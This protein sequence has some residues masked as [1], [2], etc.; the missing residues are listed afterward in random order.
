[1]PLPSSP[2]TFIVWGASIA[3]L[4]CSIRIYSDLFD[5]FPVTTEKYLHLNP[6]NDTFYPDNQK[7]VQCSRTAS[8]F[9]LPM[10]KYV[11]FCHERGKCAQPLRHK[12]VQLV[13]TARARSFC[14]ACVWHF[15][16]PCL[17]V[18]MLFFFFCMFV[19]P[20]A[21]TVSRENN[22]IIQPPLSWIKHSLGP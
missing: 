22:Q 9:F 10:S 2:L 4:I 8:C 12:A 7:P 14:N 21:A 11:E 6:L 15:V 18:I 5:F 1:M 19:K 13:S 16:F 20:R 3:V 17:L